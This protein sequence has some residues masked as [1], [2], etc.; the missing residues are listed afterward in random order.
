MSTTQGEVFAQRSLLLRTKCIT[1]ALIATSHQV[2]GITQDVIRKGVLSVVD[3]AS[4]VHAS[5]STQRVEAIDDPFKT[6][7]VS[8]KTIA[9]RFKTTPDPFNV[10]ADPFEVVPDPFKRVDDCFKKV[11][12]PFN[13][14]DD[15]FSGVHVQLCGVV[16]RSGPGWSVAET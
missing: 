2:D 8:F 16:K 11:H 6:V 10:M 3:S 14:I 15:R 5:R 12:D 9:D 1:A 13:G 4:R 7:P